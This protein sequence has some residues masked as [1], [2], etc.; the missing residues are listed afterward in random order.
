M[1]VPQ[2]D[3]ITHFQQDIQTYF[4]Q[5]TVP[6]LTNRIVV[7]INVDSTYAHTLAKL[8]ILTFVYYET[9]SV[10]CV[11][12][13]LTRLDSKK[14]TFSKMTYKLH[15]QLTV[16]L[17]VQLITPIVFVMVPI[18]LLFLNQFSVP[19]C[20]RLYKMYQEREE[21]LKEKYLRE[22]SYDD[23]ISPAHLR[24][25][26]S[27]YNR[28]IEHY[29]TP[30]DRVERRQLSLPP[31]RKDVNY[32]GERPTNAVP[33]TLYPAST[34]PP[35]V[36]PAYRATGIPDPYAPLY[37]QESAQKISPR[38]TESFDQVRA[39]YTSNV[40][41][42]TPQAYQDSKKVRNDGFKQYPASTDVKL[43][44]ER[45]RSHI[46]PSTYNT[47]YKNGD[48]SKDYG[49][50]YPSLLHSDSKLHEPKHI[51]R[52]EVVSRPK[53]HDR[54]HEP[55]PIIVHHETHS[56]R[57]HISSLPTYE[58]P[59]IHRQSYPSTQIQSINPNEYYPKRV[60]SP[61]E[62]IGNANILNNPEAFVIQIPLNNFGIESIKLTRKGHSITVK[63]T[64]VKED[65][66]SGQLVKRTFSRTYTIPQDCILQT[67]RAGY[68]QKTGDLL[69]KGNRLSNGDSETP[70]PI[71][72]LEETDEEVISRDSAHS[73][74]KPTRKASHE[75]KLVN[76]LSRTRELSP[77]SNRSTS[78]NESKKSAKH[79]EKSKTSE[80]RQKNRPKL[81]DYS[82]RKLS[83]AHDNHEKSE[84]STPKAGLKHQSSTETLPRWPKTESIVILPDQESLSPTRGPPIVHED[85][86]LRRNSELHESLYDRHGD[87]AGSHLI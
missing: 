30:S 72:V 59:L 77:K 14:S 32:P 56:P 65:N 83:E 60:G 31:P 52:P 25:V 11:F 67:V 7:Y 62:V 49:R 54:Y 23:A 79:S 87:V 6:N 28:P 37:A 5:A 4:P 50:E 35:T 44:R 81:T 84:V 33:P 66:K 39:K 13:T 46:E 47:D 36:Y 3:L 43:F 22:K 10:I 76:E 19:F 8:T 68:N 85:R 69:I 53:Y 18:L 80:N 21:F 51:Y 58:A 55:T 75:P 41:E 26:E 64:N 61:V 40:D 70:V 38:Q 45:P 9:V 27:R 82:E 1:L 71:E 16:A 57:R 15:R 48:Y 74:L 73:S 42:K 17:G 24:E 20:S 29:R 86:I 34:A 78:S 63:G 12:I 2:E